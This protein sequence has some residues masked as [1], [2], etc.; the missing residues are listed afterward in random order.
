MSELKYSTKQREA[1]LSFFKEN[2]NKDYTA[3]EVLSYLK[4][5]DK[6]VS[7]PTFY[8]LMDLL[9]VNKDIKKFYVGK[10]YHYQYADR[11]MDC[12]H[13][14]HL[15]C[16]KCGKLIHLDCGVAD[17]FINH[18]A[19]KHDFV[20]DISTSIIFGLCVECKGLMIHD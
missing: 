15:K 8:R 3:T 7:K 19:S 20:V 4:D 17:E 10:E 13:H 16:E 9:V 2:C 14:L 18:M 6:P 5:N 12:D 11:R 1:V